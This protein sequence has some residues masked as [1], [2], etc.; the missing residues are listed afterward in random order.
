[1]LETLPRRKIRDVVADHLTSY[2]TSERLK[3]GD[4]LPTETALAEQFGVSRLSLREATKSLEFLGIIAS[5]P[6][7]GLTVGS[8]DLERVTSYLGFHPALQKAPD[9][10]LIETRILIETG[11][12]PYVMRRMQ[13]DPAIYD[14][15]AQI[16]EELRRAGTW[17]AGSNW[18]LPSIAGWSNRA[19]W[20]R[21]CRSTI[22]WPCSF[23]VFAKASNGLNGSWA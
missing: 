7:V 2:I 17:P 23:S 9:I 15:L 5:K 13:V 12:L 6:G 20:R 21:C 16:V 14:T 8:V 19:A 22:C 18:T 3:P 4:R 10:Q 11:V 1:M